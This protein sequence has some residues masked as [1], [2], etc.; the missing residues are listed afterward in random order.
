MSYFANPNRVSTVNSTATPL[1]AGITF[2]GTGEDVLQANSVV[3]TALTDQAGTLYIEFSSDNTNW[4]SSL[5][6]AIVASTN[7][8]HRITVTRRYCRVRFTNTSISNQ[9]YLRI[10]TLY[11]DQQTLTSAL[12]STVQQDADAQVVRSLESEIDIASGRYQG[13]SVVNKFGRNPD[14]DTG[15]TPE[16]VWNGASIYTGFPTG[17][18]EVFQAFSSNAGDTGVLTFTYL[19]TT[20]ST[21]WLTASV[22]LNGTTPVST[23]VSGYRMHTARYNNGTATGLNLG[24]I[25]IRHSVTTANIFCVMP[26]G[27]SQ[28]AVSGYT[29]PFGCTGYV[30]R[31][32]CRVIGSTSG[33]VN[34]GL[35]VRNTG[36]SPRLRRPFSATQGDNFEELPYGG[37]TIPAQADI[38]VQIS[39]ATANNLDVI[40]GYDLIVVKN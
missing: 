19:P 40:A 34:G 38:I 28:T 9:T 3:V 31:L 15:S 4:D 5:S 35:W 37:L 30:R 21:E 24:T 14:V 11:G 32:F 26:I 8:V 27:R 6:F 33:S 36:E 17:S 29:I 1:N 20:T 2:T 39:S 10:Q 16:D 13:F 25:T 12:N 22:T 23:G 18:P 7:D